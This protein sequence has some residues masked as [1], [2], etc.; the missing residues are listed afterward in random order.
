MP[1]GTGRTAGTSGP[2]TRNA[3]RPEG[4]FPPAEQTRRA[5]R[6]RGGTDVDLTR[7][8]G[9]FTVA[10]CSFAG[11]GFDAASRIGETVISTVIPSEKER[12]ERRAL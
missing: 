4:V 6:R 11:G 9:D 3:L 5:P 1:A 10:G 7:T 12:N 8:A 2:A